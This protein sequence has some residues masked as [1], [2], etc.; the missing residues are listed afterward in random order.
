VARSTSARLRAALVD[1]L[2]TR[3]KGALSSEAVAAALM[4]VPREIFIPEVLAARGLEAVYRDEAHV[5]KR[6][7]QGMPLSSSSQPG[8]MA[9]MLELLDVHPGQRVLEVGAGTGYNA[10]LLAHLVGPGGR[11]T[12]VDVDAGIAR[13]AR[14]A[15]KTAGAKARVV[16]GDGREGYPARAPYD[17]IIVTAGAEEI[18]RAWREQLVDRGRIV[19]PLRIDRDAGALQL[20]PSLERRGNSLR[21]LDM[22]WGGFMPLHGGD[23]GWTVPPAQLNAG[24][25]RPSGNRSFVSV[26]GAGAQRLSDAAAQRL[27]AAILA[28][29]RE[30][31]RARGLTPLVRGHTPALVIYLLTEIGERQRV[32]VRY[33]GRDG[34]GIVDRAG[35]LGVVSTRSIW[36]ARAGARVQWRLDSYGPSDE[37]ADRLL[38]L[39]GVWRAL[40]RSENPRLEISAGGTA[41][42][43]RLR[44]RWTAG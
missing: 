31:P 1:Q 4:A 15:L 23:G 20:I 34:I 12:A 9:E 41:D 38:R 10:A 11:V 7:P 37:A 42:P 14:A 5:T 22:T 21:S 44:L 40:E 30:P 28:P 16:V 3:T 33:A 36:T 18:P 43:M 6:D 8:L 27:L 2:R 39:L 17:R 32:W 26:S 29:G 35:G 24:R 25:T 13:R 19:L